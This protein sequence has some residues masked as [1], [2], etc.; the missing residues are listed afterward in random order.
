[1]RNT[2]EHTPLRLWR[3]ATAVLI[4]VTAG[5]AFA[6]DNRMSGRRNG[7]LQGPT[8]RGQERVAEF[9]Q[10]RFDGERCEN[11]ETDKECGGA[12]HVVIGAGL[13]NA[14]HGTLR[15]RGV[16]SGSTLV[17][18]YLYL[19]LIESPATQGLPIPGFGFAGHEVALDF[20][21]GRGEHC[22][23]SAPG[24]LLP[25]VATLYR[26]NVTGLLD[27]VDINGDYAVFGAPSGTLDRSDP[28]D[29][30]AGIC[31]PT[32]P[33]AQGASL[34]VIYRN[35][36]VPSPSVVYVHEPAEQVPFLADTLT[37]THGLWPAASAQWRIAYF[38]SIGGDG[39]T[40]DPDPIFRPVAPISTHLQ[41][42]VDAA[43]IRGPSSDIEPSTDWIGL[44]GGT[45]PQLWGS[46]RTQVYRHEL[47]TA[48]VA[49]LASYRV[50]Y[51]AHGGPHRDYDCVNPSVHVL[52][53]IVP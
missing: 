45:V 2:R 10:F 16:P 7:T 30:Q 25:G 1:M 12:A 50:A 37:V 53:L 46:R 32:L 49:P 51:E 48:N 26:A 23:E 40:R 34:V 13:R 44:D 20:V 39:Q 3:A 36:R 14:G 11:N 5:G 22:W 35:R 29:C 28:F 9:K 21:A 52:G 42:G 41:L 17:A 31:S 19:G 38:S 8:I 43:F 15:L 47:G 33:L 18:A 24:T 27:P 6:N 4:L